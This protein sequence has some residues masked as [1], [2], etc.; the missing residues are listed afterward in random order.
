MSNQQ[1]N[2]GCL[3]T[4][5]VDLNVFNGENCQGNSL[6]SQNKLMTVT[7]EQG[8]L[9]ENGERTKQRKIKD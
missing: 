1:C 6:Q 9:G 3:L 4:E 5:K 2:D 8:R 7:G